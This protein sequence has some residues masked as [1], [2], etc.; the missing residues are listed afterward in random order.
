MCVR[1]LASLSF[2][3]GSALTKL[4]CSKL[5]GAS[6]EEEDESQ[7]TSSRYTPS[8]KYILDELVAN[9]L[10]LD[11]YPSVVPMPESATIAKKTAK[12]AKTAR[13][14]KGASKWGKQDASKKTDA[15]AFTGSR[16]LVF[17]LGA[18]SYS[19]LKVA[20]QIMEKESREIIIGS[21]DFM[22]PGKFLKALKTFK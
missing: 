2:E 12:T 14:R 6:T 4:C 1:V 8:I 9:T 16:K 10:S 19:E 3:S 11:E 13:T 15:I 18:L 22:N 7:Y 5:R 20:R 17:M 21:T